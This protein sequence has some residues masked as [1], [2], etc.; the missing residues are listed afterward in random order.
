MREIFIVEIRNTG[1]TFNFRTAL[2]ESEIS[3]SVSGVDV[4]CLCWC[5]N[6]FV[7]FYGLTAQYNKHA[8]Y[9]HV[10]PFCLS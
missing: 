8:I 4:V 9:W 10:M 5:Q 6:Y 1:S 7:R 2:T 3:R